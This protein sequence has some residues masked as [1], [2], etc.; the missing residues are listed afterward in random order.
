MVTVQFSRRE[1]VN[2][3][4]GAGLGDAASQAMR[5]LPGPVDPD[6]AAA[7]GHGTA[8]PETIS[9][10]ASAAAHDAVCR[11]PAPPAGC[12]IHACRAVSMSVNAQGAGRA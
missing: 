6:Q 7:W 9:S 3:V 5:D 12:R 4:R 1:M 11:Q 2:M 8:S 10:A